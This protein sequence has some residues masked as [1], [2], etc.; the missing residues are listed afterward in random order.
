MIAGEAG[1][2]AQVGVRV[3]SSRDLS[4]WRD[5]GVA[6]NVTAD[7]T[8]EIAKGCILERPKVIYNRKTRKFV[9]WFHLEPAGQSYGAARSGVAVADRVRG[10]YRYLGLVPSQ[11]RRVALERA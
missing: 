5:E 8:S 6:L 4:N 1:N 2:A 11:R 3:Y 9:M 7:P 10:P